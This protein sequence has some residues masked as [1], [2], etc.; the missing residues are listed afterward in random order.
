M[1]EYKKYDYSTHHEVAWGDL[2]AFGHVNNVAYLR[3]FETARAKFFTDKEIWNKDSFVSP[4]EGMVLTRLETLY[5]KQVFYPENLEIT[6]K[7]D[8]V[9]SRGFSMLCSMWNQKNECVI[10]CT[11]DFVWVDFVKG[12]PCRIPDSLRQ[13]IK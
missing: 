6:L 1:P 12:K 2:D 10:Y 9:N 13:L 8:S 7:L 11:A 3:Y 5:R 4:K